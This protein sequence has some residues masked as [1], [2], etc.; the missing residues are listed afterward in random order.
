M[1]PSVAIYLD[2]DGTIAPFATTPQ[3]E[4]SG[5]TGDWASDVRCGPYT[6]TYALELIERLNALAADPRVGM[7]WLSSW[8]EHAPQFFCGTVGL[9]GEAWPLL[10]GVFGDAREDWWKL[11]ALKDELAAT[12]DLARV[13]VDDDLTLEKQP[14][15]VRWAA[16][17]GVLAIA[18]NRGVGLSQQH[19]VAIEEFVAAAPSLDREHSNM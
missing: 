14:A 12:P 4:L 8:E 19:L 13:W 6:I 3:P 18:P 1:L 15:A 11:R 10:E 17:N 7:T 16:E 5:W 2:I 9:A